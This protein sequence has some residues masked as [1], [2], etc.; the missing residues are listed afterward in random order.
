MMQLAAALAALSPLQ[1]LS[2]VGMALI[3]S[4][5]GGVAG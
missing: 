4:V 5:V 2:V 1:L 3:A